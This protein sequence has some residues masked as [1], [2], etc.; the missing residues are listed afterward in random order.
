MLE[1]SLH[2]SEVKGPV[3]DSLERVGFPDELH[4][5]VFLSH[6]KAMAHLKKLTEISPEGEDHRLAR[7]L[8]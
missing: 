3:M 7:G 2:L 4:G 1:I 6:D 5:K 8:I